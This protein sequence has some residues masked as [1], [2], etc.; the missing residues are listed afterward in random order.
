MRFA[1]VMSNFI[2]MSIS[3]FAHI[4]AFSFKMEEVNESYGNFV[5]SFNLGT[6]GD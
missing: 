6:K 2:F 4:K 1:N 5:L 3:C